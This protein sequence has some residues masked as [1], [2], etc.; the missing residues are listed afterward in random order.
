[1]MDQHDN[2]FLID[3]DSFHKDTIG[4]FAKTLKYVPYVKVIDEEISD[5]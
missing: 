2:I 4:N 5:N 3:T 1:M